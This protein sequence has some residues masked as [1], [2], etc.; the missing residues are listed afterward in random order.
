[1]DKIFLI[2]Q[3]RNDLITSDLG[4]YYKTGGLLEYDY[5]KNY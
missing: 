3:V 1:M 2:S 5:F 4:G